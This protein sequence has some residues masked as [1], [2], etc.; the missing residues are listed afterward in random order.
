MGSRDQ[1]SQIFHRVFELSTGYAAHAPFNLSVGVA[2]TECPLVQSALNI[3]TFDEQPIPIERIAMWLSSPYSQGFLTERYIR[4]KLDLSLRRTQNPYF[5]LSG[6]IGHI[7][8]FGQTPILLSGLMRYAKE[9][10]IQ[11]RQHKHLADWRMHIQKQLEL[12]GFPGER[13]LNSYE[14]QQYEATRTLL[15][16]YGALNCLIEQPISYREALHRLN[17]LAEHTL[18]QPETKG[19]NIQVLGRLEAFGMTFD[20]IWLSEMHADLWPEAPKP[21]PFIPIQLQRQLHM[22]HASAERQWAF[23]QSLWSGFC[24]SADLLH[25]SHAKQSA[26][27]SLQPSRLLLNLERI[28]LEQWAPI[29]PPI[30]TKA[31]WEFPEADPKIPLSANQTHISG[32]VSVI[33]AQSACPFRAFGRFRLNA[34]AMPSIEHTLTP[35]SRGQII[36]RTLEQIW[37]AL[38]DHATLCAHTHDS[39]RVLIEEIVGPIIETER[40]AHPFWMNDTISQLERKRSTRLLLEWLDVE[41]SRM[42]FTVH[43]LEAKTERMLLGRTLTMRID[44]QDRLSDGYNVLIDYKTGTNHI[45]DWL[46]DRPNE[47]QLLLYWITSSHPI[48]ALTFAQVQPNQC[49]FKGLCDDTVNLEGLTPI[50]KQ[51][52]LGSAPNWLKFQTDERRRLEGLFKEFVEGRIEIDPKNG[53]QTCQN[54]D[55]HRLC[56]RYDPKEI[57]SHTEPAQQSTR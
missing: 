28:E 14:Y 10:I 48:E 50:S 24:N 31:D 55:L 22:P 41:R 34:N 57:R 47:P 3:L 54:C 40:K 27:G 13:S 2:L 5:S 12:L 15:E 26:E 42:P 43:Q 33:K 4:A 35:A 53:M 51:R 49:Q 19:A 36:H 29:A 52:D 32:G 8:Q 30:G 16:Q 46:G 18:F 39:L 56:R 25:V 44:R 9:Q 1:V 17:Q 6:L 11:T 45:R 20:Q 21:N 37:S 7:E 38:K 23:A